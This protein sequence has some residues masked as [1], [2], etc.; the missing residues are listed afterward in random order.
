M[1]QKV[2]IARALAYDPEILLMDEPFSALDEINRRKMD[3]ELIKLWQKTKKTIIFVTH[4]IEEAIYL[5]QRVFVFS[6]LPAKIKEEIPIKFN[7]PRNEMVN[8]VAFFKHLTSIR[9]LL[10]NEE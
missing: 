9:S 7:Y 2:S 8:N 5:S 6:K 1:Q 10:E 4:S 3:D